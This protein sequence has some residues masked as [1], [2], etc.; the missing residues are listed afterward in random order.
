MTRAHSATGSVRWVRPLPHM[1][2]KGGAS[3]SSISRPAPQVPLPPGLK[4]LSPRSPYPKPEP[5]ALNPGPRSSTP[6]PSTVPS[7]PAPQLLCA[8]AI[9]GISILV[10]LLGRPF[11]HKAQSL[12]EQMSLYAIFITLF[13]S[14]FFTYPN[15]RS[16]QWTK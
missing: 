5:W 13:L 10:L 7:R 11:V 3:I 15:V 14:I 4:P 9:V 6:P 2:G 1:G 8:L 12:L 16:T